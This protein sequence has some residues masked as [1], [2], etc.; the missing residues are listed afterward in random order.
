MTVKEQPIESSGKLIH[1]QHV[2]DL[3]Q[4]GRFDQ[5]IFVLQYVKNHTETATVDSNITQKLDGSPSCVIGYHP[6]SGRYFVA[7]KSAFNKDPKINYSHDDIQ[8]NHGHAPGLVEKLKSVF[9]HAHKILPTKGI[10][11]GDVL[12]SHTDLI[13][14]ENGQVSFKPNTITYT[15]SGQDADAVKLSKLGIALHTEYTGEN[16]AEMHACPITDTSVFK[17]HPDVYIAVVAYVS[18]GEKMPVDSTN[19]F[20]E[21]LKV[22][23]E[24][25][26]KIDNAHISQYTSQINTYINQTVRNDTVQSHNGLLDHMRANKQ[27]AIEG[28]KTPAAKERKSMHYDS[29]ITASMTVHK[30]SLECFFKAHHSVQNSKNILISHMDNSVTGLQSSIDGKKVGPEGYVC[31]HRGGMVKLVNRTDFSRANFI[32]FKRK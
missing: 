32:N 15:A 30:T 11:Q 13:Y 17:K 7:S 12:H 10:F 24:F 5:A 28:V 14:S 3:I 4:D 31:T 22:A 18:N 26:S 1:L 29:L 19:K 21:Y 2:E 23:K 20:N 9:D 25:Y 27:K 8:C 16:L 6:V